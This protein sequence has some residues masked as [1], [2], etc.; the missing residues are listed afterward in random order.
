MKKI[1]TLGLLF[2]FLLSSIAIAD[3]PSTPNAFYGTAKYTTG[4]NIPDGYTV[5][6]GINGIITASCN[7]A[8]GKYG[9]GQD[10]CIVLDY[11]GN[12]GLVKFYING[13]KAIQEKEFEALGVTK[14]DLTVLAP[15]SEFVGCG[16][17]VCKADLSECSF[18]VVDCDAYKTDI[19]CGNGVCALNEDS[20]ICPEDCKVTTTSS[21]SSGGGG[22][23]GGGSSAAVSTTQ[24]STT[25]TENWICG[26]WT[27]CKDSIQT[28]YCEDLNA[29]EIE[30]TRPE[31]QRACEIPNQEVQGTSTGIT[32]FGILGDG[33]TLTT[34]GIYAIAILIA[35]LG[36]TYLRYR[37]IRSSN[38]NI[39]IKTKKK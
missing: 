24:E 31:Q 39:K 8:D 11:A 30:S 25:C 3:S 34:I 4:G 21:S 26:L 36:V 12:G 1:I 38:K 5:T 33:K 32:G 6:A 7:V 10:T 2:V 28:R 9:Y 19:C 18:C 29:C 27:E 37:V 23:G 22:G 17:N 35:L 14:L 16:D 20:Y 15:P 13:K